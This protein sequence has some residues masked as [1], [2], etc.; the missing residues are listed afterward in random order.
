MSVGILPIVSM[1]LPL[2]SYGFMPTIQ[3]A[4]IVGRASSVNRRKSLIQIRRK[5]V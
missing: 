1:P 3:N 2:M 4:F 5:P